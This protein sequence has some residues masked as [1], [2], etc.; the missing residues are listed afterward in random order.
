VKLPRRA[1]LSWIAASLL[2]VT[3]LTA[4]SP[5]RIRERLNP[6]GEGGF[7]FDPAYRSFLEAVAEATPPT[8]TVALSVPA[9]PD[10]YLHRAVYRLAP[11]RVVGKDRVREAGFLAVYSRQGASIPPGARP[12][13][14][15]FLQTQ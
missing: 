9:V 12:I 3:L 8:A 5:A 15:G 11:R 4:F 10:F 6:P 1:A 14:G 13:P 7:G 2:A